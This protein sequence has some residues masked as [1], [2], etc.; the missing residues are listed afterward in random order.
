M[1]R[2]EN[3]SFAYNDIPVLHDLSLHASHGETM[4]IHG[5]SGSGKSTLLRVLARLEA[6]SAGNILLDGREATDIAAPEYRR[7]VAYLQQMPVMTDGNIRDNLLLSFRYHD[8][9]PPD[10][11]MLR[12]HLEEL[13]LYDVVLDA[14]ATELSV[15]QQQRL[16]L[17]RLLLMQ[18][19]VL[20]LD[21]PVASLDA[22]SAEQL[23]HAVARECEARGLTVIIVSH[24]EIGV[25]GQ[26][27]R[28]LHLRNGRIEEEG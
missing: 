27:L 7:R 1:L 22:A 21:E 8:A 17:L 14:P 13:A 28:R 12:R 5:P 19:S 25:P 6:L 20:L 9:S 16:A 23:M 4:L 3:I 2:T 10:D 15:G 24:Q 18:P 26:H 11:D